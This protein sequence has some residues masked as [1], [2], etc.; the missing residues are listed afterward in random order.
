[1][2][3]YTRKPSGS[4]CDDAWYQQTGVENGGERV[5]VYSK[6]ENCGAVW[7]DVFTHTHAEQQDGTGGDA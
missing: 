1:M 2:P 3:S 7:R 6:C 4:C 5:E